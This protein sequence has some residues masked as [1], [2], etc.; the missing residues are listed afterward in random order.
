MKLRERL[1]SAAFGAGWTLVCRLPESW[2][3]ALFMAGADIA[4]RRP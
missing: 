2:A 1:L 4:W 3:R